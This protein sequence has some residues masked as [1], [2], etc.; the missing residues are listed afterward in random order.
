MKT[1]RFYGRGDDLLLAEVNGQPAVE[2]RAFGNGGAF[3]I[4]SQEG[5]LRVSAQFGAAL[6]SCWS[7]GIVLNGE[8]EPIPPWPMRYT[9]APAEGF[10]QPSVSSPMLTIEA[11]DDAVIIEVTE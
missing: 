5:A 6:T 3:L 9:L 8:N 10:P 4:R 11:P 7:I 2:A 1:L